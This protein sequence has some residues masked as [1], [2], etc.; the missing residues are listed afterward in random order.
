VLK[1]I[2]DFESIAR[3]V[4]GRHRDSINADQAEQL[5]RVVSNTMVKLYLESFIG[6]EVQA[7]EVLDPEANF[8]VSSGRATIRTEA[9]A[10]RSTY[11]VNYSMRTDGAGRWKVRNV[12]IDG[13]NLGLT[14]RNQF[15]GVM[16]RYD[17]DVDEVIANWDKDVVVEQQ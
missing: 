1:P 5:L 13:I 16:A 3:A 9:I 10:A 14:Y 2:I 8:D 7:V 12:I 11:A 17:Q 4:T 6:F 15:D